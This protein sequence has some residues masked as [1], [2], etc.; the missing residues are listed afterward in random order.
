M[1]AGEVRI[2]ATSRNPLQ[3]PGRPVSCSVVM[4]VYNEKAALEEFVPKLIG[5]LER[6]FPSG[7]WE[8]IFVDDGSTDRSLHVLKDLGS[9]GEVSFVS[10][11]DRQGSGRARKAGCERACGEWIMWIDADGTY[12]PREITTL[13]GHRADV[14]QVIGA[15]DFEA[16]SWPIFRRMVKYLAVRMA[17]YSSGHAIRDLNSGFRAIRRDRMQAWIEELPRGFSC[18]STATLAA[19]CHGD[20]LRYVPICYRAR[21]AGTTSKFHPIVDTL[22]LF[23]IILHYHRVRRSPR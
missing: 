21:H 3:S 6:C 16:G 12:D 10:H 17:Q 11:K 2:E 7:D 4:P 9:R 1:S 23:R 22:R 18:T 13:W 14:D 19:L 5:S 8:I 20:R 15:R